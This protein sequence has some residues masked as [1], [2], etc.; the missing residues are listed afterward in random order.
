MPFHWFFNAPWDTKRSPDPLALGAAKPGTGDGDEGEGRD[1]EAGRDRV[2][3]WGWGDEAG[4]GWL[5]CKSWP[6]FREC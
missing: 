4:E 2:S 3:G 1:M 5:R 6:G